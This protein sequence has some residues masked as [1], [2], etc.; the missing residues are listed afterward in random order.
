MRPGHMQ[1]ITAR[2]VLGMQGAPFALEDPLKP[3]LG[4][5]SPLSSLPPLPSILILLLFE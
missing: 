2:S 4:A 5:G 3:K 1:L